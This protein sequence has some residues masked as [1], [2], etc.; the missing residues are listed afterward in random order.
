MDFFEAK[1]RPVL[2]GRCYECHSSQTGD[3]GGNLRLDSPAGI[4]SGGSQGPAIVPGTIE[5]S[6]L[7]RAIEYND[8]DLQMPPDSKLSDDQISDFKTWIASGAPDPRSNESTAGSEA[9]RSKLLLARDHWAYQSLCEAPR[10]VAVDSD[11]ATLD[12]LD[13]SVR[14]QCRAKGLHPSPLADRRT[15][16]RRLFYDLLGLP[17]TRAELNTWTEHPDPN[18][19][20]VLVDHLLS[21]P[22]FGERMARRWMDVMR[23][24]D[25]KG[26]VF[27]EDRE[28][29]HASRYRDWLI[30]SFN[31]DLAYDQFIRY[32]LVGDRL[33]SDNSKGHL[34]AMGMLTLGRRFLQ[35]KHDIVDDRIDVVTRGLLG[36]TA[37]CARCHDHKFDP[38]TMA[39]YYS[40]H[41]AFMGSD[42]PGGDPSPMRLVDKAEQGP[43]RVFVRG[44]PGS[45]GPEIPRQFI[46]FLG[47]DHPVTMSTGSGRQEMADSIANPSNPLTARVYVNRL[48]G[49]IFGLPIVDTPSDFGLRSD[50]PVQQFVLDSLAWELMHNGWSTKKIVRRMVMSETYRQSSSH[51]ADAFEI[52]PE[53]RLFWR[54]IRK[55]MDFE[56]YRDALLAATGLLDK[57]IGGPSVR[58]HEP[59]FTSRRTLYAY[60]DRQNLPQLFRSFDFA[61]PDAHVPLRVQTTVPQQGL[62]LMNSDLIMSMLVPI[63]D[64]A[65]QLGGDAGIDLLFES[66]LERSPTDSERQSFRELLTA[67]DQSMPAVPQNAWSYGTGTLDPDSGRLESFLLLPRF[68]KGRWLGSSE[69]PDP[70]IEWAQLTAEGGHP[71]GRL[72]LAVARRWRAT[73][74]GTVQLRGRLKHESDN[75]DGVRATIVVRGSEKAGQW[76]AKK[77]ETDTQV[78]SIAVEPGD[79]IDFVV[80]CLGGSDSDTFQWRTR[81]EYLDGPLRYH[82]ERHFSASQP[83]VLTP[84]QQAAQVLL[85]T[86]EFCFVD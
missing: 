41:A 49:W 28:Y 11:D 79:T 10:L 51:R 48:W 64:K 72:D 47:G 67:A 9:P 69:P 81:V 84:W 75:G 18:W 14:N 26:Y 74:R 34:D 76:T 85:L 20:E 61:S 2:V 15:L 57:T 39:D 37:S 43:T 80:D 45:P 4:Q 82:S 29:P 31:E 38:V 24:A 21:S 78:D 62:L 56:S 19:Y 46:A 86:N 33:D 32:Q 42:E 66:I 30:R 36:I 60:I 35:N 83:S 23:Y 73:E 70:T 27:Q 58:I 65:S 59:P 7:V 68:D 50:A 44:S 63:G 8:S 16:V 6:V 71:G 40:M 53:N 55:R 3:P 52:D 1:I 54:A 5:R 17:P 77:S 13:L 25:N 22:H 12:P